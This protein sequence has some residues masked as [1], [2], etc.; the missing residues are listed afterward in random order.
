MQALNPNPH[1]PRTPILNPKTQNPKTQNPST[2]PA[3]E[4]PSGGFLS[5]SW[6]NASEALPY[7]GISLTLLRPLAPLSRL[8]LVLAGNSGLRLPGRGVPPARLGSGAGMQEAWLGG[9]RPLSMGAGNLGV[10]AMIQHAQAV[11][12]FDDTPTVS[13]K[14]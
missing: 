12:S 13:R 9:R 2:Q 4:G 6:R 5:A 1:H 14:P 7:D 11:G 10:D 3:L 8:E